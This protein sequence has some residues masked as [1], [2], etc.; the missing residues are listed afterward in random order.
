MNDVLR[1]EQDYYMQ[2]KAA[3]HLHPEAGLP[4]ALL[5]LAQ[6]VPRVD[7]AGQPDVFRYIFYITHK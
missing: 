4:G 3:P 6:R 7:H 1:S 5:V 2:S